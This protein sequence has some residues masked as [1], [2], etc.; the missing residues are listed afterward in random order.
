MQQAMALMRSANRGLRFLLTVSPVPLT[1]TNSGNHVL[2]ATVDSKSRLR[3]VAGQLARTVSR[4]DYFPSYEI[5]SA[6]PFRGSFFRPAQC[7][8]RRC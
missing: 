6:P 3:A 7:A 4:V 2:V 8:S 5:I 1:A